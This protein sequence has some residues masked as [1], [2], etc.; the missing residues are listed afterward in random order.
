MQNKALL[1]FALLALGGCVASAPPLPTDTTSLT[2]LKHSTL[3]DFSQTDQNLTCEQISAEG[4]SIAGHMKADN[5]TIEGNR[6]RNETAT[7]LAGL[8]IVALPLALATVQN[9][10]ERK[11][12]TALYGRRDVLIKLSAV[13]SCPQ[14]P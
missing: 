9:D 4:A 1:A 5:L 6:S 11:E 14:T 2:A 7:Y 8:S 12:V 10:T 13:K 3:A